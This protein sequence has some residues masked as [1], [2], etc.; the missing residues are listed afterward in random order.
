MSQKKISP[1]DSGAFKIPVSNRRRMPKISI[2]LRL[3]LLVILTA[4]VFSPLL[5]NTYLWPSYDIPERSAHTNVGHWTEFWN[6]E[7]IRKFDPISQ[8]SYLLEANIPGDTAQVHRAI[9]IAL[10]ITMA[11]F[12]CVLLRKMEFKY[13]FLT[14][15]LFAL[16]PA[17]IQILFWPGYRHEI[18]GGLLI[19]TTLYLV[20]TKINIWRYLLLL[21]TVILSVAVNANAPFIPVIIALLIFQQNYPLRPQHFNYLLPLVCVTLL[22]GFWFIDLNSQQTELPTIGSWS[23][24]AGQSLQFYLSQTFFPTDGSLFKPLTLNLN[25]SINSG[26]NLIPFMLFPPF[27]LLGLTNY[28]K[29]WGRGILAMLFIFLLLTIPAISKPGAFIDGSVALESH[30]YYF[31]LC[32]IL[33]FVTSVFKFL[34]KKL[35]I[36]NKGFLRIALI[37]LILTEAVASFTYASRLSNASETWKNLSEQW[38]DSWQAQTIYL[39]NA[40]ADETESVKKDGLIL[41]TQSLLDKNPELIHARILMARTMRDY[42]QPNNALREF[43]RVIRE[44]TNDISFLTEAVDL[45]ELNNL[46]YE[47]DKVRILI[48]EIQLSELQAKE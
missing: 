13:A 29:S 48:K 44:G 26:I 6:L 1:S 24:Q 40:I 43:Q 8:S 7:N 47:A 32:V 25:Y 14:S 19:L 30:R 21:L 31:A 37:L 18:L 33:I 5:K 12:L 46:N 23:Y 36:T 16:H 35:K 9:N 4:A 39:E 45:L 20:F 10:H 3:S 17:T 41:L 22:F 28:K 15:L 34:F 42:G 38:P 2:F 11:V 27:L